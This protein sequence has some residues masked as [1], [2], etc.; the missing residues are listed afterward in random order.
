MAGQ[1]TI[2]EGQGLNRLFPVSQMSAVDSVDWEDELD[3]FLMEVQQQDNAPP[4]LS[5]TTLR[6]VKLHLLKRMSQPPGLPS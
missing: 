1:G 2:A 5:A 4:R 3:A 6:V